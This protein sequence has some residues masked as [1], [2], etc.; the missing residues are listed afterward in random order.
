[1]FT[2]SLRKIQAPSTLTASEKLKT[3]YRVLHLQCSVFTIFNNATITD[4]FEFVFEEK[5]GQE[6]HVIM[7]TGFIAFE[8]HRVQNVVRQHR[9]NVKPASKK[10]RVKTAEF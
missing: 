5:I 1:M 7:V 10:R 6:N 4:Y 3:V 8:K 2:F 9:H